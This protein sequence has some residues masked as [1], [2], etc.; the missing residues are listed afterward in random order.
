MFSDLPITK[1][2]TYETPE[3]KV[4]KSP[5]QEIKKVVFNSFTLEKETIQ[6]GPKSF[7]R[8]YQGGQFL[9]DQV[10][11]P[12]ISADTYEIENP[13]EK[14][15]NATEVVIDEVSFNNFVF[16]KESLQKTPKQQFSGEITEVV[17]QIVFTEIKVPN[18]IFLICTNHFFPLNEFLL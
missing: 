12:K 2:S 13:V 7:A 8:A 9:H 4:V 5:D 16:E 18:Y 3:E 15:V 17:N 1:D 10:V 6:N 11:F 14:V